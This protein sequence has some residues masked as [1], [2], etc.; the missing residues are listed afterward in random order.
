[1]T[2]VQ[3][4]DRGQIVLSAVGGCTIGI[5][6]NTGILMV[7]D[8][9]AGEGGAGGTIQLRLTP[10]QAVEIARLLDAAVAEVSG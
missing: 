10:A 4:D 5:I 8:A 2:D 7:I 9:L 1:M 3:T 6:G